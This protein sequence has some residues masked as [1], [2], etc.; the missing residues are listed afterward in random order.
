MPLLEDLYNQQR[1]K[2][3]EL[4]PFFYSTKFLG[5][6]ITPSSTTQQTIGIQSDSH[7]VARYLQITVYTTGLV[8]ATATAPLEIQLFDTGSGRTMFDQPQPIQNV[9]GGVAAAAGTGNLPFIIPEP[10]LIKAGGTIQ[11]TIVNLSTATTFNQ[12]SFSM[13][14]FKVFQFGQSTAP[15]M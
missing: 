9:C 5:S 10:W 7:F 8:V 13:P 4:M 6:I 12:V 15:S 11:V 1:A 14:G 2:Q 3:V